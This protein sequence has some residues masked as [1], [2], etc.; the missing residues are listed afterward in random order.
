TADGPP[1]RAGAALHP[2]LTRSRPL[3]TWTAPWRSSSRREQPPCSRKARH[4]S[5]TPGRTPSPLPPRHVSSGSTPTGGGCACTSTARRRYLRLPVPGSGA[6]PQGITIGYLHARAEAAA[7]PA[8]APRPARRLWVRRP[9]LIGSAFP[10][11][12]P[13]RFDGR[14]MVNG[15][16]LAAAEINACG[17][18]GGRRV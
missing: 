15:S 18:I 6:L 12:G 13:A 2:R 4:W 11:R 5:T 1:G 9:L 7:A 14:E 3:S 8:T 17:G 16:A 10:L